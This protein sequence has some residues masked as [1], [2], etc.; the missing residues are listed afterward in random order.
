MDAIAC[1]VIGGTLL[2]GGSGFVA[3]TVFG[4]L[5]YGLIKN[6]IDFHGRINSWWTSII[7]GILLLAFILLQ[8]LIG[9]VGTRRRSA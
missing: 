4:V 8:K 5:V 1:V 6:L 9:V 7:I 2:T 3:G